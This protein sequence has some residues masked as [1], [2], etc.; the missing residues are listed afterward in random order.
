[1]RGLTRRQRDLLDFIGAYMAT[2]SFAPSYQE[3]ADG[4]GLRSKSGIHRLLDGLEERGL[5]QRLPNRARCVEILETPRTLLKPIVAR[6]LLRE[7]TDTLIAEIE[8]RGFHVERI[9]A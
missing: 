9:A 3:M 5:I 4:I 2:E 8:A 1:M 6:P 7:D